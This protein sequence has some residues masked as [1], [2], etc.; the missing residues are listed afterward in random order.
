MSALRISTDA[1]VGGMR[2]AS[3]TGMRGAKDVAR[4]S[5][6]VAGFVISTLTGSDGFRLTPGLRTSEA[7]TRTPP[8]AGAI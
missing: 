7:A 2:G 5:G 8:P 3:E 4:M 6:G 1:G